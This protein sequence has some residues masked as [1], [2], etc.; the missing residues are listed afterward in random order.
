MARTAR[1]TATKRAIATAIPATAH[2]VRIHAPG[3]PEA[4][5]YDEVPL[6]RPG[7][8]HVLL[9]QTAIGVNFI[10]VYHRTGA[11]PLPS[12]PGG[13]G[14]EAAGVVEAVGPDTAGFRI[15]DRVAYAAPPPG[16][17]ASWRV[18]DATRMVKLPDG[19]ADPI[20]AAI[21]LQGMTA[22]YLLKQTYRVQ[23]GDTVLVHAAAGGMG[24]ILCQWAKAL[25]ATV[26]GTTSTEEKAALAKRNGCDHPILYT[27]EDFAA[28]VK[29]ITKGKGVQVVY[30]GIGKDTLM[31]SIEAL[32]IRGVLANYGSASGTPDPIDIKYLAAK[33]LFLTRPTL[34]QHIATRPDL[35]AS[36]RDVFKVVGD[37]TVTIQKPIVYPL[38]DAAEAHRAL[39]G[40]RT[41]GSVV[42]L[43]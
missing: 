34:F 18:V 28:R 42:L 19:I 21:M 22:R 11:Y 40:R 12:L 37:G 5:V 38:K 25:G 6:G 4:M 33:S 23:R 36:A 10:D 29:E 35:L 2:A 15:G 41:T 43:P 39:E 7:A 8:G 27:R 26:I 9:R 16:A 30:D 1:K 3:G 31:G 17:Y 20:A 14:M 13:I 32:A 24:L